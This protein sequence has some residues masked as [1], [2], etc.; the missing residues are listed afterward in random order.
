MEN[1]FDRVNQQVTFL[2]ARVLLSSIVVFPYHPLGGAMVATLKGWEEDSGEKK[3][4]EPQRLYAKQFQTKNSF[5]FADYASVKPEHISEINISFL[6]WFIGFV[7][8]DGSFWTR[9]SN[10]S[11]QF[12]INSQTK[13]AEFEIVQVIENIQ[14][15]KYIRTNLGFG[16][17]I[18]FEKNGFFY[19]RFYTSERKNIIRLIVLFNGN[20]ILKKRQSQFLKWFEELN[21]LWEL[22]IQE[23]LF[24]SKISLKNAW[25]SGFSDAD[26]GFYTN[27]NTN[28]RGSKKPKGDYY[29][30]FVTKFYITQRDESSV[31]QE[32]LN[33]FGSTKKITT[34]TNG[35]NSFLYNRIEIQNAESTEKIISYFQKFPLKSNRKIDYFRWVRVHAYKNMHIVATEK[36][37]AKLA[38]LVLSLEEPLFIES[39]ENLNSTVRLSDEEISTT[40]NLICTLKDSFK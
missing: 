3:K 22:R 15:L 36:A 40:R 19:C 7:E 6:I 4:K 39:A 24:S 16:R 27:V 2:F 10:V 26:A 37:A 29:V 8:G 20:F 30:K 13:R 28:F 9:D 14:L 11:S 31:L 1:L 12:K 17:V 35:T 23:K 5:D 18:T 34:I 32:I 38:R 33:L 25:L 21:R